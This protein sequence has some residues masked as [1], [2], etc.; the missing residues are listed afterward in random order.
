MQVNLFYKESKSKKKNF[1]RGGGGGV[2]GMLLVG[3]V[4]EG[5]RVNEYFLLK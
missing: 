2:G 4:G 5:A 1:F 3:V